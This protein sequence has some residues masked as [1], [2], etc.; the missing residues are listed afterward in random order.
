[1]SS[2]ITIPRTE[3]AQILADTDR[4]PF[5]DLR[6]ALVDSGKMNNSTLYRMIADFGEKGMI[7]DVHILGERMILPCQCHDVHT[8][9]AVHITF[10]TN[11]GALTDEHTRSGGHILS[12]HTTT[13]V[14]NCEKCIV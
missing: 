5:V 2:R 6:K 9:D 14:K 8:N 11:C 13:I 12:S 3:F 1:M 10:C 4:I 7:H